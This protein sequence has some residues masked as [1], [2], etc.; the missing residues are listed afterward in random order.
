MI[1]NKRNTNWKIVN[2]PLLIKKGMLVKGNT[3]TFSQKWTIREGYENCNCTIYGIVSTDNN[4]NFTD[5]KVNK[6][7]VSYFVNP[8]FDELEDECYL[9]EDV[10]SSGMNTVY[11]FDGSEIEIK[12]EIE[13]IK[14]ELYN[15]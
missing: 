8:E 4:N 15:N 13:N 3:M 11:K 14:K 6:I 10:G 5:I 12:N 7:G 9:L 1:H 2:N